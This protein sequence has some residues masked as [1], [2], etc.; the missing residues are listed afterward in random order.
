MWSSCKE[1]ISLKQG[2]RA[3]S[4]TNMKDEQEGNTL[5]PGS[6]P[7]G[8]TLDHLWAC[9]S[10]RACGT[11]CVCICVCL[12]LYYEYC[13]LSRFE[14]LVELFPRASCF[15]SRF[16]PFLPSFFL[17]TLPASSVCAFFCCQPFVAFLSHLTWF[18]DFVFELGPF[19]CQTPCVSHLGSFLC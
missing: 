9:L 3:H 7:V 12:C 17:L 8:V 6:L 14:F 2:G 1:C 19:T 5:H 10:Q 18:L 15:A 11:V 4:E 13:I 16:H